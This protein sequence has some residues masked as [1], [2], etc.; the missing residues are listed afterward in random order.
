MLAQQ[1][2]DRVQR[3][4]SIDAPPGASFVP[5]RECEPLA[6]G[7]LQLLP[8]NAGVQAMAHWLQPFK[9]PI[10]ATAAGLAAAAMYRGFGALGT[11][12][13]LIVLETTVSFDNAVVNAGVL[14]EL[15][16]HWRQAFLTLGVLIAVFGMRI[17]FPIAIVSVATGGSMADVVGQALHDREAYARNVESAAPMIGAFGG[18]FLLSLAFNFLLAPSRE[19]HWIAPVERWLAKA[20]RAPYAPVIAVAVTLLAAAQWVSP[21]HERITLLAGVAGIV[22][23]LLINAFRDVMRRRRSGNRQERLAG[24]AG[25]AGFV[26]LETL[27]ASFS[28]DGVLGAFAISSDIV[29]VAIGLGV[30]AVFVRSL[31]VYLVRH[32]TLRAMPY[33]PHGAHWAIGTLGLFLLVG[34]ERQPPEWLT[35]GISVAIVAAAWASSLAARRHEE[36]SREPA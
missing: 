28:L 11:V 4:S 12:A 23:F 1:H 21:E 30:G 8:L 7:L 24:V 14:R 22:T 13:V 36:R 17:L 10:A 3:R 33:L 20:G 32:E 9:W 15:G 35:G 29:L 26:Y 16:E 18:T 6:H 25:L 27:D 19:R 2:W 34:I 5:R 31:T